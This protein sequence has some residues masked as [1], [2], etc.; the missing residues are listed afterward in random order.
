MIILTGA[1]FFIILALP[2]EF[3]DDVPAR[4][5]ILP[6]LDWNHDSLTRRSVRAC[7]GQFV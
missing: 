2:A 6:P 3:R 7:K 1:L 4:A 5:K